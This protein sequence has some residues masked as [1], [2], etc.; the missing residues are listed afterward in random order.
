MRRLGATLTV[1]M[2]V[3]VPAGAGARGGASVSVKVNAPDHLV[4]DG[5]DSFSV[6]TRVSGVSGNYHLEVVG[7]SSEYPDQA[8]SRTV[9]GQTLGA[10]STLI[11]IPAVTA[12][13]HVQAVSGHDVLATS[14]AFT[15]V[16][17][18]EITLGVA[19]EGSG[20]R[21]R[22]TARINRDKLDLKA[23]AGDATEAIFYYRIHGSSYFKRFSP[24]DLGAVH[25]SAT[26]CSRKA[27][28]TNYDATLLSGIE[29][30]RVCFPGRPFA[31]AGD[32]GHCPRK[33]PVKR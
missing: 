18:P 33:L 15:V 29:S 17:Y 26:T 12:I 3:L 11:V 14:R 6:A 19:R 25:C 16:A 28:Q 22:A 27:E 5:A 8:V 31:G 1:A 10:K 30:F 24:T 13:Y 32:P 20:V 7:E 9:G 4:S 2:T 21:L 23:R